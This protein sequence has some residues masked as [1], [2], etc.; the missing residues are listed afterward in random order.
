MVPVGL[1][2]GNDPGVTPAMVSGGTKLNESFINPDVV[3]L[4]THFGWAGRLNVPVDNR[5]SSC[6]SCHSTAQSPQGSGLLPPTG[7]DDM[8]ALGVGRCRCPE[9]ALVC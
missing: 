9:S 8:K 3:P 6:L 4:M 2:W 5:L 7:S 1:M